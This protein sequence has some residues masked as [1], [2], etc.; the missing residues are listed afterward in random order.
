MRSIW[1]FEK[2]IN[3]SIRL[4]SAALRYATVYWHFRCPMY[5]AGTGKAF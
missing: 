3:P 1:A 2:L 5:G 4:G